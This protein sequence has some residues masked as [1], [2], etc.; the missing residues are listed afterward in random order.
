MLLLTTS[1]ST[2]ITTVDYQNI[3]SKY[4]HSTR[5]QYTHQVKRSLDCYC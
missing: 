2:N 3:V 4:S 1:S 5:M